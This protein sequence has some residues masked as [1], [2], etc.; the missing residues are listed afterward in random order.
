MFYV[1]LAQ[2]C[3]SKGIAITALLKK[4]NMSK[5]SISSW[6]K[7]S[8][9][10]GETLQKIADYFGVTTDYLLNGTNKKSP[11]EAEDIYKD[12]PKELQDLQFAFHN[13]ELSELTKDDIEDIL[14]FV[15]YVK[16]KHK[17]SI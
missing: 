6:K 3:E 4:L 7:G 12:L 1:N 8:I 5:G 13:P 10:K 2:L 15:R 14:E 16:S 9:P 17:K 11:A